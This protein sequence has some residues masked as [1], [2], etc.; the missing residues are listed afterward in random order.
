MFSED[1]SGVFLQYLPSPDH[2]P[3]LEPTLADSGSTF[4]TT[5]IGANSQF[6]TFNILQYLSPPPAAAAPTSCLS[7]NSSATS[8]EAE[9][10]QLR[11]IDERKR[12]RMISNRES[13]R[14]SRMRKQRHLDELWSHVVRLRTEKHSLE[15]RL[16]QFTESHDRVLQENARLKEEVSGL[17]KMLR[18]TMISSPPD[19]TY[20]V[21]ISALGD[22]E[23]DAALNNMISNYQYE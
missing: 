15:D 21:P 4:E 16:T 5:V 22:S 9:E 14:R 19:N 20:V 17:K 13:A 12:R 8:D 10:Q 11:A 7:S 23:G 1:I 2:K 3:F 18:D 6:G